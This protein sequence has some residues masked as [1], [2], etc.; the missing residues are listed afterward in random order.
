MPDQLS[1]RGWWLPSRLGRE[2]WLDSKQRRLCC[3]G[4]RG[5]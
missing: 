1:E 3:D 2:G 5:S 4:R